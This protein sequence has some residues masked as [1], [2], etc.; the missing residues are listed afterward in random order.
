LASAKQAELVNLP[1]GAGKR[2]STSVGSPQI[3]PP[4]D[5][6]YL[7]NQHRAEITAQ[8]PRKD[9]ALILHCINSQLPASHHFEHP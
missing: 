7:A 6:P 3:K 5:C 1:A 4:F 2:G 9:E 8:G